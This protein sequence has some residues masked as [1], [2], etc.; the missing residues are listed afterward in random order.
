MSHSATPE[1]A[2][3]L[4]TLTHGTVGHG[5][6][7]V[8]HEDVGELWKVML[9]CREVIP[10]KVAVKNQGWLD[11]HCKDIAMPYRKKKFDL[12]TLSQGRVDHGGLGQPSPGCSFF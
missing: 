7:A 9:F 8:H 3:R 12:S 1:E 11:Q 4:W 10:E 2:G 5:A 6:Q